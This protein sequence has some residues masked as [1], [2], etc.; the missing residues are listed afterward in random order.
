MIYGIERSTDMR[1][2]DTRIVRFTSERVARAWRSKGGGLTHGEHA[3]AVRN[4]HHT[5]R[6]LYAGAPGFRAVAT[7][8]DDWEA[9]KRSTSMYPRTANDVLAARIE[10]ECTEVAR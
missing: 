8:R 6:A 4:H 3:D 10:S 1:R 2:P 5:H 7:E 9:R